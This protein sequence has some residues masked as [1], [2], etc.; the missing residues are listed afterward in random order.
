LSRLTAGS[1]FS[2]SPNSERAKQDRAD[3]SDRREYSKDIQS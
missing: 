1:V 2:E 3:E